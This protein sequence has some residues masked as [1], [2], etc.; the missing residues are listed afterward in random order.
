MY[1]FVDIKYVNRR[2]KFNHIYNGSF[3]DNSC[4]NDCRAERIAWMGFE[5]DVFVLF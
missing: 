2:V 4:F 5:L 1:I 3:P